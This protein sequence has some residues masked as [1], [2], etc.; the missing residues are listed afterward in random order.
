MQRCDKTKTV[1]TGTLSDAYDSPIKE[2]KYILES[3]ND[4][5]IVVAIKYIK[6]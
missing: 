5:W 2:I 6:E 1:T 3:R 4:R